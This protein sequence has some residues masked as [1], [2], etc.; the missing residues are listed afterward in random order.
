MS[1]HFLVPR[2]YK[3]RNHPS[4][5]LDKTRGWTSKLSNWFSFVL[6]M[7]LAKPKPI[8]T[9]EIEEDRNKDTI[10]LAAMILSQR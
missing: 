2:T 3:I 1:L 4:F 7:S 6:N 10:S 8:K 9:N 5:S